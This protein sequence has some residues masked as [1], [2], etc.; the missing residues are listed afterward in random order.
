VLLAWRFEEAACVIVKHNQPCGAAT[1]MTPAL[2]WERALRADE[3]SAYGGVVAF[4]R[5]L[6]GETAHR[7]ARQFVEC[8]AAPGFAPEAAETLKSKKNLRLLG[9]TAQDLASPDP[10]HLRLVGRWGLLQREPDE[11]APAWNLVTKRAPSP[12]EEAGLRFAWEIAAAAR[13]NAIA[14]AR[15]AALVGLGSGQTSRVDA[16]DLAILKARRAGHDLAG[17]ALASDGFFPFADG[18][19]HAAAAGVTAV[20]QPGGSMRDGEVIAACDALGVTML[21]TDRREFRH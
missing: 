13:S 15:G 12:D 21:F 6:D 9:L 2:A 10:W 20:V 1:A 19:E 3:L 4:N 5:T 11:P 7:L 17:A 14:I 18:V 16:V 8:V